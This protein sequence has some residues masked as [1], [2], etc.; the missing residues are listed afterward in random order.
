MVL[1]VTW[2]SSM[3]EGQTLNPVLLPLF[4]AAAGI[5]VSVACTYL[6]RTKEGGNPQKALDT[7]TFTAAGIMLIVT[8]GLVKFMLGD[9][10]VLLHSTYD[11]IGV[12][13]A[14]LGGLIAGTLIGVVTGRYTVAYKRLSR[15][16]MKATG[17]RT[18]FLALAWV[19][20]RPP[21]RFSSVQQS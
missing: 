5:V 18:L 12:F 9:G 10:T 7:G 3:A 20:Y 2:M 8:Y 6:V 1:G 11:V 21:S 14:T 16:P 15:L 19:W 13:W 4:V 17:R